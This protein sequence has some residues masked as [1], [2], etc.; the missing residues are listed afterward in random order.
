MVGVAD[1]I[2]F[3]EAVFST[4]Q[5]ILIESELPTVTDQLVITGPGS[6]LLTLDGQ[7]GP[8]REA[9]TRDGAPLLTVDDGDD[10]LL[11][12]SPSR[13]NPADQGVETAEPALARPSSDEETTVEALMAAFGEL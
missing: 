7:N 2:V 11:F 1:E 6:E 4:P 13:I 8:D 3:D 10:R 12:S 5:A 9:R